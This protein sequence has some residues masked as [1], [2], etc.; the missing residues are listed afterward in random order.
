[1]TPAC[2][3]LRMA[4]RARIVQLERDVSELRTAIRNLEMRLGCL[5]TEAARL[6]LL[7]Q[8][9]NVHLSLLNHQQGDTNSICDSDSSTSSH[10]SPSKPPAHLLQLFDNGLLSSSG[11]EVG[12]LSRH[13]YSIHKAQAVLELQRLL[14]L[15]EDMLIITAHAR[16]WLSLYNSIFP[17][18]GAMKNSDEVLLQYA[19][20]Q[21][22]DASHVAVSAVLL[23]VALTV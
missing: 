10:E 17:L 5:P 3:V 16:S 13:S 15:R 8:P 4:S 21:N 18:M 12:R 1:M 7:P 2:D 19:K 6:P 11:R 14:P 22:L 23:S 20:L 9:E